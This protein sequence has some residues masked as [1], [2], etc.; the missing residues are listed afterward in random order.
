MLRVCRRPA[1]FT[2]ALGLRAPGMLLRAGRL[3]HTRHAMP[4]PSG[5]AERQGFLPNASLARP[6]PAASEAPMV[7]PP[8]SAPLARSPLPPTP[9]CSRPGRAAHLPRQP[10]GPP[11][12]SA[13]LRMVVA[14]RVCAACALLIRISP[15][16]GAR[17][18]HALTVLSPPPAAPPSL[19]VV[20]SLD[21]SL[22][23]PLL[24]A[25]MR[26]PPLVWRCA[27]RARLGRTS[28]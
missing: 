12:P 27:S 9:S 21:T 8:A 1:V 24:P 7:S 19:P 16:W 28:K 2:P 6:P 18:F 17:A 20:V 3:R 23:L 26:A 25:A 5:S 4:P 10:S 14:V 15:K 22:L 11:M 13:S